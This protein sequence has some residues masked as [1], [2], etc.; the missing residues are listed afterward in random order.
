MADHER[1]EV[2]RRVGLALNAFAVTT[3]LTFADLQVFSRHIV[4]FTP[5][6]V[7]ESVL[8]DRFHEF[9]DGLNKTHLSATG[10]SAGS[11]L[12]LISSTDARGWWSDCIG[13][14]QRDIL[15]L[16]QRDIWLFVRC[17]SVARSEGAP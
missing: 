3:Q 10:W 16:L 1:P 4:P 12:Q 13:A 9:H 17:I 2:T 6:R 5:T 15:L 7:K 8:S 11:Y 14:L